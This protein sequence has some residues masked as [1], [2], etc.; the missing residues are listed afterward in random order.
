MKA[1]DLLH[2]LN[3]TDEV[4]NVEAKTGSQV[5]KS[6]LET[7]CAFSNEPQLGGGHILLGARKADN[8]LWPTYEIEG[9]D[10]PDQIQSDL[11]TQ[12]AAIFN[13]PVRPQMSVESINNKNVVVVFVRELPDGDKPIY[14]KKDGL[15]RGAF[16]R[17]GTTDQRCTDEDMQLFAY[18]RST[19]TYDEVIV[20]DAD[21]SDIDYSAIKQYREIRRGIKPDAEELGW[22]D[23]E[24][25][26]ALSCAKREKSK[27]RPTVAGIIMFGKRRALRRLFPLMRV[28]YIRVAGREWVSDP[29]KR[30]DTVE[31]R[32]PLVSAVQR[33]HAT[34][35][36]DIPKGFHLNSGEIQRK[37]IPIVPDRVIREALVNALMHRNYRLHSPIQII[38]YSNR[39]EIRNPGFSLT[40]EERFGEPGS[41]Q[42]NPKIAGILHDLHIAETKGSGIR[43]MQELMQEAHLS[44]PYLES[45]RSR[46]QF[47][48]ILL[49]HH[50]LSKEDW[51]WLARFQKLGL[52]DDDHRA[53]IF[54]REIG[55]IN[56]L[57]YRN[58]NHVD[59][60]TASGRLRK[61]RDLELIEK[62]GGGANTYYIPTNK[63]LNTTDL[64][65]NTTDLEPNTTDL[66]PNTTDL[67]GPPQEIQ[68]LLNKLPAK[69]GEKRIFRVILTLCAWRKLHPTEIATYCNRNSIYLR[70]RYLSKLLDDGLVAIDGPKKSKKIAYRTTDAGKDWLK[71]HYPKK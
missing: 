15:P 33:T 52:S 12:C 41:I 2:Q 66:E 39:L 38:R 4:A 53:L 59:T 14:F 18:S 43:V 37:E 68:N 44:P 11:A 19:G 34:V 29:N 36:D 25:L 60:L 22:S 46:D 21:L 45:D 23:E 47:M 64:E 69:A 24:L 3:E 61:I 26:V 27:L 30:F 55:A 1:G 7:V 57:G 17:I 20:P 40:S 63:L 8:T 71:N 5:G 54:L 10:D 65:P 58:L 31:I 48:A 16:R 62:K 35:L 67:E 32:G 50:F 42:R 56:N 49:F 13:R 51:E 28:D 70:E 6:I 9:I